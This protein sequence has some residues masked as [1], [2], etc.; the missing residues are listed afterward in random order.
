MEWLFDLI[1]P[2][3]TELAST[4][5]LYSFVIAAGI[6]LGKLKIGGISLGVTFVL[7]VGIV[8]GHF[9]YIVNP[10]VLKFV[11][12][13]GLILFIFAIGIQVG[14]GFFS[15]FKKGGVLLNGLAVL[16]IALNVLITLGIF[17]IDGNTAITALVGVMSGAV[18]NTPGL[19]AAQQTAG[20]T[21][22]INIMAMGY[23]A[24][25]PLGVIGIIL[26][27]LIIKAIFKIRTEDEIRA[28][29]E[30]IEASQQKPL[31]V[32]F[33]VTNKLID[34]KNLLELHQILHSDFIISRLM[35]QDGKVVIPTSK[36]ELHVGDK[37]F[38]VMAPADEM[39]FEGVVG[40][41]IEMSESDWEAVQSQ[42]YSRRIVVTQSKYN[43]VA[44]G[45]LRLH[46]AYSLNCTRVNRAGVDL[47]ASPNLRLQMGDRLVVVGDLNDIERLS[48]RLGNSM[49]RL[50]HPNLITIFVGI[51]FGI[52]LGSINV[53]FG[54]KLG[55]AGGPLVVAILL[56]RFG[57][58]FKLV[59]YTSSSASLL[60]R[61]LGICLFLASVGISSG[62]GFA[63]T[64]FNSTGM[65]WVI[66]GFIITFVPLLV[67]GCIARGVYKINFLTIM[68]LVSGGCTDPPAL[69]YANNSTGSDAPAVA[70]ST[71]YPLTMFLRVVAAQA[72]IL[73]FF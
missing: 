59:T 68:G 13:F 51:M 55:L 27:M 41:R 21:E 47:I 36:T 38:V 69:A 17:Y 8:M 15:S 57:Y 61:E 65:W 52:I 34:G 67:V 45:S 71:V 60:M 14:P 25:Y 63:D 58:K 10:E 30:E 9:G 72:L 4:L 6:F 35:G 37:I 53:G 54:M 22:A 73:C 49:K 43:G 2:G 32:S 62:R 11:R 33:E 39:K 31:V 66:W 64:V 44:L 56:S 12:E 16:I 29:E 28:I 48:V 3:H 1:G 40:H 42:I 26:S 19:A 23:A 20:T 18:T 50:N 7:F 24:A 5:V 46:T 70:Y